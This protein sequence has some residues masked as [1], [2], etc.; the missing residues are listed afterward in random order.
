V[1]AFQ[2]IIAMNREAISI[3]DFGAPATQLIELATDAN[4]A[5]VRTE[6]MRQVKKRRSVIDR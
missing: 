6:C 2:K 1:I 4:F 5:T 3:I